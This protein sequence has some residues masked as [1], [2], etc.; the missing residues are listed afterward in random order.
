[1]VKSFIFDLHNLQLT[2]Y[3]TYQSPIRTFQELGISTENIDSQRL[4]FE[5]KR[6]LLEIQISS[7]QT[8][9]IGDKELSKNDV[10]EL[11]DELEQVTHLDYHTSIF[12]HSKLLLLLEK[13]EVST[14]KVES[15]DKIRFETQEEWDVFIAFISPYLAE[16][17]DKLLSKVIRKSSFKELDEIRSF[18]KLLTTRDSFYAFRKLNNFCE[19]LSDRLEHIAYNNIRFP[20]EQVVYLRYAPFYNVVNE[21]TGTYPNLPNSV[22]HAIINFTVDCQRKVGREKTLVEISD[23]ARR[24][25]CDAKS[26]SL[27]V[28]NRDSFYQSREENLKYNPNKIW[29]VIVGIAVVILLLFRITNRC[30]S[31]RNR[32]DL[33]PETME[34]M[35]RLY[36]SQGV[37]AAE[38]DSNG[39]VRFVPSRRSGNADFD[40]SSFLDLHEKIVASTEN[41]IYADN[42]YISQGNP[43]IISPFKAD[44]LGPVHNLK[45]ETYSDMIMVISEG[46]SL[47]SYFV[48]SSGSIEFSAGENASIFFYGGKN[49]DDDRTIQHLHRSP[50]TNALHIIRFNGHFSYQSSKDVKFLSK[51]FTLTDGESDDFI[52]K[53]VKSNYEFYQGDRFVNYSF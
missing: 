27:I 36:E 5:R 2:S 30:D 23:Q 47:K 33:S 13:S 41:S 35:E 43:S 52:I 10:I 39:T 49:W 6:L 15:K 21:L 45:N 51:Y 32:P 8:T 42:Y 11:F 14:E 29:R 22:A 50:K 4:R 19:T 17:I 24:L 48:K 40:E 38:G 28:N 12:N 26:K 20:D 37:R 53:E 16:S 46:A 1:M 25:H 7:T 31:S 44:S 18:F 9:T 34:L 3:P